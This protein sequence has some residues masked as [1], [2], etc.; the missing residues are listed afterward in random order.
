MQQLP[1]PKSMDSVLTQSLSE[2]DVGRAVISCQ[3]SNESYTED[4]ECRGIADISHCILCQDSVGTQY[5][6]SRWSGPTIAEGEA[7]SVNTHRR[8]CVHV[9]DR[10]VIYGDGRNIDLMSSGSR[11]HSA[12][13]YIEFYT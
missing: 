1:K 11:H 2:R 6:N 12:S 7:I 3:Y 8:M 9:A 4:L 10:S 5:G 13:E